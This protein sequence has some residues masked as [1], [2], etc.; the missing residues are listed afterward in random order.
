M[1]DTHLSGKLFKASLIVSIIVVVG[2]FLGFARDAVIAAFYGS[3]WQ[4][5]AFFLALSLP[6]LIFPAVCNS[7]S[8]AFLS[9]YVSKI[10][11]DEKTADKYASKMVCFAIMLAVVLSIVGIIIAPI[12]VPILAPGF[13]D[14]Q[15]QLAISLTRITMA[16]FA[17]S[18]INYMF[19][20]ILSSKK[21]FYGAQIAGV[22]Y[23][24]TVIL[25][26]M[27]LGKGQS[28][29]TLTLVVVFGHALQACMMILLSFKRFHFTI[30]TGL[31]DVDARYLL[32]LAF[33]ILLGNSI[34]QINNIVDKILASLLGGGGVSSLAYSNTLNRFVT[35]VFIMMLATV[36]Y[37]SFTASY[38]A[39]QVKEFCQSIKKTLISLLLVIFPISLITTLYARDIVQV[40]YTRG[41]FGKE[42]TLLTS[43]ALMC[44]GAMYIFAALQETATRAF[45]A[46]KD[47]KTPL[48]TSAI[49]IFANSLISIILFPFIGIKGIALGTTISTALAA[50]L[51]IGNLN[52]HLPMLNLKD[53]LPSVIKIIS[54]GILIVGFGLLF[55]KWLSNCGAL[56]R[57]LTV[58]VG[59]FTIYFTVL[60]ILKCE[61]ITFLINIFKRKIQ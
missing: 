40:V 33:P 9:V 23:N 16:A 32:H 2:K 29:N 39:G 27:Y 34:I 51:L 54:A 21:L 35:N 56:V 5:D 22:V 7:V 8:T 28:M 3:T 11:H 19:A 26:I 47:T 20:A 46:M 12:L 17:L 59:L 57:F 45:Y 55:Q 1:K 53:I 4:T 48:K 6:Y 18:M 38:S 13:H 60:Y 36:L 43:A 30:P 58:T 52:K 15:A 42:A 50:F 14:Q 24:L 25:L 41:N 61:E 10:V 37:P 49:A 44:Y 31:F